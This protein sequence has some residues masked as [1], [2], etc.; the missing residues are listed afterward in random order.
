MGMRS[1]PSWSRILA[2]AT[3]VFGGMAF[4][5]VL[6][7]GG[8]QVTQCLALGGC[9]TAPV[10]IPGPIPVIGTQD[11]AMAILWAVGVTWVVV[12]LLTMRY[13]W[14][15]DPGRLRRAALGTVPIAGATSA[16]V[17]LMNLSEGR[18]LRVVAEDALLIGLVAAVLAVPV[19]LAWALLTV[20]RPTTEP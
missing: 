18:R 12:T 17:A 3:L 1:V 9:D 11:G 19:V 6:L 14:S 7:F 2:A 13:V 20:H 4:L 15:T 8:G 16:L 5:A 10:N